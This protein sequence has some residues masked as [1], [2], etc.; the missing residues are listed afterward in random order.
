M[1]MALTN[2]DI[3]KLTGVFATKADLAVFATK[4]DLEG[5]ATKGD[6][7][8]MKNEVMTTLDKVMDE[9]VKAREDRVF[10]AGKDREQ[11]RRL[12]GLE[13]RVGKLEPVGR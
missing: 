3:E 4:A 5:F 7:K 2:K 12:D 9:L 10:A 13:S 8:G 1:K 11:D 6:L